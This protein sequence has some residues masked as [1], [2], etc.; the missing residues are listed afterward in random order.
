MFILVGEEYELNASVLNRSRFL[1]KVYSKSLKRWIHCDPCEAT[2]D[3]P[4]MYEKGWNKQL[5]YIIAFSNEEVQDVTWR[6]TAEFEMV[7]LRRVLCR[8]D[9]LLNLILTLSNQ[10]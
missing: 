5:S 9:D 10:L 1:I 4:L 2:I 8:E 7:R 6:Y 3:A